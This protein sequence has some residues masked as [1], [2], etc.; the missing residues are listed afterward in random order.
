M[1]I[2]VILEG[3]KMPRHYHFA[4][5]SILKNALTVSNPELV[6]ALYT[7]SNDRANKQI[8]P[9]T[10]H[11][12]MSD[13]EL[14]EDD[15]VVRGDIRL[16][17]SSPNTE[18]ILNLYNGL[19]EQREFQYKEYRFSVAHVKV[20]QEK[21]PNTG[22]ILC[23]TKSPIVIRNRKGQFLNID[24]PNYGKELNY[25]SN[26][27]IKQLEGRLLYS[28]IKFTPVLMEKKVV[29]LKHEAFEKLNP[30]K[31]LYMNSYVGS[32]ILEGDPRDLSLLVQL[33][34]GFRRSLF[35][36]NIEFIHE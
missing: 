20:L 15:F 14:Q 35:F 25:I 31:V 30:Q 18:F 24:D 9:F 27:C 5:S 19:I 33:G 23:Q 6:D 32:F 10:G 11:I 8:K 12:Q 2:Q 4:M 3:N 29:Q 26:E 36:G 17:V 16:N 28:P 13:Y 22:K 7:F 1:R 21:L 34:L